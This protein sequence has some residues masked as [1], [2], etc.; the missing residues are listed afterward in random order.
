MK[1][2][3]LAVV[4]ATGVVGQKMIAVLEEKKLPIDEYV[5]FASARSAGKTIKFGN[6]IFNLILIFFD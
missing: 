6:N 2:C 3:K 5:F 1:K 4:G